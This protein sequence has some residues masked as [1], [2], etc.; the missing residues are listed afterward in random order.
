M[1][2]QRLIHHLFFDFD[3]RRLDD[4]LTFVASRDMF[5]AM[6]GWQ[7]Y[8]WDEA[9]VDGVIQERYPQIWETYHSLPHTIQRLDAAKY[10]IID[11]VGGAYAD[12]DVRPITHL[13]NIVT[14][15]CTFDFCS[16]AHIVA[17]D[18]LYSEI[19]LPGIFEY[20]S[21]NLAR[22]QTIPIYAIWKMRY[23]FQTT[24]P[25]FFTRYLKR[26]GL[27]HHVKHL[28]TRMFID[29]KQKFREIVN[30]DAKLMVL[31]HVSWKPHVC[32]EDQP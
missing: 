19:G 9:M 31:H 20:L 21:M 1:P 23:V 25:D 18:F 10:I 28:S 6:V 12:L 3:G 13:D 8:L 15:P 26:A 11:C 22:I 29:S 7:Y 17:N 24:G 16:R 32:N 2:L 5:A 14:S 30:P 27:D 4:F